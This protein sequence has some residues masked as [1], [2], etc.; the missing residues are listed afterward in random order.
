MLCGVHFRLSCSELS[1]RSW[2]GELWNPKNSRSTQLWP[3][4]GKEGKLRNTAT[5]RSV[6]I[7]VDEIIFVCL[8]RNAVV[9]HVLLLG[10]FST[11]FF[12]CVFFFTSRPMK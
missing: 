9:E 11:F 3:S 2:S 7:R 12:F 5:Y 1:H 4:V 6:P 8:A 10:N